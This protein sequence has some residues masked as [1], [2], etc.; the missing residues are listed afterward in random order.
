MMKLTKTRG[1]AAVLAMMVVTACTAVSPS[2][3]QST[4]KPTV[5]PTIQLT[6]EVFP[7]PTTE[8]V[9]QPEEQ[10]VMADLPDLGEAPEIENEVWVN[11]DA[12]VTLAASRGK[13]VLVEF[14]TFG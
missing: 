5:Q 13:V 10:P 11:A 12:P 4:G 1:I 7:P 3:E 8:A 2:L 6:K 14:W 9:V